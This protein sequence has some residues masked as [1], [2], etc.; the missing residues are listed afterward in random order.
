VEN[1][2]KV[3]IYN[4]LGQQELS[5]EKQDKSSSINIDVMNMKRGVY[6]VKIIGTK[7]TGLTKK[8]VLN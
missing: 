1:V 2:V 3:E 5:I 4:M 7:G 6:F 8:L